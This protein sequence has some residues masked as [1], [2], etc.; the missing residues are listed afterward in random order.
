MRYNWF[1]NQRRNLIRVTCL[2]IF[3]FLVIP[4]ASYSQFQEQTP[5]TNDKEPDPSDICVLRFTSDLLIVETE[6]KDEYGGYESNLKHQDFM[7]YDNGKR[8]KIEFFLEERG[9]EL[10]GSPIKYRIGYFPPEDSQVGEYRRIR[11]KVRDSKRLRMR[12]HYDPV[13]YIVPS[14]Q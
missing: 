6:V 13:D 11:I 2:F 8:Q 4:I 5:S 14:K 7:V 3:S 9:S 12:V 1:Y 10:E